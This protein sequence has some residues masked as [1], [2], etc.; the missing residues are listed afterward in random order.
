MVVTR[1]VR[2]TVDARAIRN[3]G[4]EVRIRLLD[5]W[6]AGG[7]ESVAFVFRPIGVE[8]W[9]ATLQSELGAGG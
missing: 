9:V 8:K 5:D 4:V 1:E 2:S 6:V 3:T 7:M